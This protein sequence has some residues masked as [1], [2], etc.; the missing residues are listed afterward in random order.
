[1]FN[2]KETH[3]MLKVQL[4]ILRQIPRREDSI[5]LIVGVPV[6]FWDFSDGGLCVCLQIRWPLL[7][8]LQKAA[9]TNRARVLLHVFQCNSKI[10]ALNFIFG[11]MRLYL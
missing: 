7:K 9:R 5:I 1:M 8:R 10:S 2:S 6:S 4:N 3:A 11:E